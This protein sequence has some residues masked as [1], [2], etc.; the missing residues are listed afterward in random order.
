[1][2]RICDARPSLLALLVALIAL[3]S[4]AHAIAAANHPLL[5][6]GAPIYE[7]ACGL[8]L[9]PGG[10]Y[11]SDY[12]HDAIDLP[13]GQISAED[14][15]GGPCGLAFDSAGDLYVN[16]WHQ[17][18]VKYSSGD[19]SAGAGEVIDAA[20]A[21]GLA[22][23]QVSGDLFVAHHTY[24][25]EYELSGAPVEVGGEPVKIGLD[26][27]A[28]YYGLAVSEYPSTAGY[29]YVPDAADH[30]VKVFDPAT[31]LST[32]AAVIDG[33]ATP[34]GAFTYLVD[35]NVAVDNSPTSPSYGHVFVLD[36]IGHG[37]S[38]QPE[39][40][41]DE[42]NA[43]GDY[44]GQITGF[45]DAE[46]SGIAIEGSTGDVYVTS[47]N[48]EGSQLFTY[49]PTAPAR[50]LTLEKSGTGGGEVTSFPVGIVCG[51]A[52]KAEFNEGQLVT[53]HASP[54][55]R[56]DFTGWTVSGAE[57]C[58]GTGSCAVPMNADVEVHANFEAASL[59]PLTVEEGGGGSGTVTSEPSGLSCDSATCVEEF[60]AARAVI[61]TAAPSAQSR[62][63][64]WHGCESQPSPSQC[65]VTMNAARAVQV[66]FAPVPRLPMEVDPVGSGEGTVISTPAGI[67]CPGAACSAAFDE[68]S[69]VF[70]V[71]APAPTSSFAGFSGGGCAGAATVCAVPM[72]RAQS[73]SAEFRLGG[74]G[75][76]STDSAQ[77]AS[78]ATMT[79][80]R[81]G[82]AG[83]TAT[84]HLAV[85][86]PGTLLA[87][88]QDL[89]GLKANLAAG[90]AILHLSLSRS[91]RRLLARQRRLGVKVALSFAPR[92]GA[93]AASATKVID[94]KSTP[95]RPAKDRRHHHRASRND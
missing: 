44:R 7:D 56:S 90:P 13:G 50:L 78:A 92:D 5:G 63:L 95:W 14:P 62:L 1:M 35:S 37:D 19:F 46:P 24:I 72:S 64:A 87:A 53:L 26:E 18:V 30:T 48:T 16:N 67:S 93:A 91:A 52:C 28:A 71:A 74:E 31:S 23:D 22:V 8:A 84:L 11:V 58:P 27:G 42:F 66:E 12:Y 61:L 38:E 47:G 40:A 3:L 15:H 6:A 83:P 60:A 86:E 54:D 65:E 94:F 29:L 2:R 81:L 57:P 68:G 77:F 20:D 45:T 76:L 9:G 59:R 80:G 55:G 79:L 39:G 88:G 89:R 4:P 33:Q 82:V 25:S 41:I 21:T 73:V 51:G 34:Q 49:G 36:A 10:L 43:Q 17:D 69:T 70:L 75:T 85:S 32:P